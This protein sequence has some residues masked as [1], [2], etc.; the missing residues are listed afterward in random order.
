[1]TLTSARSLRDTRTAAFENVEDVL[2]ITLTR[3]TNGGIQLAQNSTWNCKDRIGFYLLQ[4]VN[5]GQLRPRTFNSSLASTD[6]EEV[7][8]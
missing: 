8:F 1:M 7:S 3:V 5:V 2:F 6:Q 4:C